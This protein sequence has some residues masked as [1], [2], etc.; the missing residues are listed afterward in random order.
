[1]KWMFLYVLFYKYFIVSKNNCN[2]KALRRQH[3]HYIKMSV[4]KK[5]IK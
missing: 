1:M 3:D 2:N 5:K 4:K